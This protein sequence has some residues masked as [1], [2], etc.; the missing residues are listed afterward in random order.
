MAMVATVVVG[1]EYTKNC[2]KIMPPYDVQ[3]HECNINNNNHKNNNIIFDIYHFWAAW[4]VVFTYYTFCL[5]FVS[6]RLSCL[7]YQT[8]RH[9]TKPEQSVGRRTRTHRSLVSL[10]L[11][12][13]SSGGTGLEKKA[14]IFMT[15]MSRKGTHKPH[16]F[17]TNFF[18]QII[19]TRW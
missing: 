6:L 19:C 9:S 18:C 4:G 2:G 12:Y 1:R 7:A 16:L 10:S 8:E 17:V 3:T 15:T 11:L 14:L 5:F 13:Y